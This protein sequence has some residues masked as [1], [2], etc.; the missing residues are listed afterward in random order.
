[1]HGAFR[2][3]DTGL[4]QTLDGQK[5][6]ADWYLGQRYPRPNASQIGCFPHGYAA[7]QTRDI[8]KTRNRVIY[9]Q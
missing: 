3:N 2:E 9:G 5:L 1:M 8:A 4:L 6:S 7:A